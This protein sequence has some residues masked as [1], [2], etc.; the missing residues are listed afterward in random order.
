MALVL[1]E[2]ARGPIDTF[3]VMKMVV[4]H[5]LVEIYARDTYCYD[6]EG[7]KGRAEREKAAA[8]KIFGLLPSD[9]SEIFR[10]LRG[11]FEARLTPESKFAAALDRLQPVMH[12]YATQ[13]A[14]WQK[15]GVTAGMVMDRNA[16]IR[17][18][19]EVLWSEFCRIVESAVEKGFLSQD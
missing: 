2:Y 3:R 19:S 12:N 9:Q 6:S 10:Q 17:E 7:N 4:I 15:H 18:G 13:G 1:S 11:E 5:D 8:E 14:V 16:H